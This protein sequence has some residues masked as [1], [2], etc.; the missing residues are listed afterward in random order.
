MCIYTYDKYTL[1]VCLFVWFDYLSP[2][3]QSFNYVGTG[4]VLSKDKCVLLT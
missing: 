3:H 2:S 1:L 4:P